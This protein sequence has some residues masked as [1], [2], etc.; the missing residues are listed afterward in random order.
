MN[1]PEYQRISF[2]ESP[3]DSK[4]DRT[5]RWED[6]LHTK[7]GSVGLAFP[8][9]DFRSSAL[10][11]SVGELQVVDFGS[12]PIAYQRSQR[13]VRRD[14]NNGHDN[15][16]RL[17]IPLEG[18]FKFAQGDSKE[19]FH[20]GKIVLCHWGSPFYMTHD[21]PIRALIMTVPEN[22]IH[23][24]S[25][26]D[27]PLALNETR[28]VVRMLDRAVRQLADD[29]EPW[30]TVDF[31]YAFSS[32]LRLLEGALTSN[33]AV[34]LRGTEKDI[35]RA[36]A[37]HLARIRIEQL[38][39]D[40]TVTPEAIAA[41]CGMSLKKLHIVLKETYDLTPG[42]MLRTIRLE[43]AR[44]QLLTPFPVDTTRIAAEAGFST[45]RRFREAFQ[46]QFGLTPAQ[47]REKLFGVGTKE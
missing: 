39:S 23:L 9:D 4:A 2:D 33:R 18:S 1:D 19:I 37:A 16:H 8:D 31:A 12:G 15:G 38:A 29:D 35:E 42:A 6:W 44:Q 22:S 36:K 21:E 17:I 14:H 32:A 24:P 45:P 11:R 13:D 7:Q 41:M 34:A 30:T 26:G 40:P 47:M 27:A 25:P 5:A 3:D 28:P 10:A 20:P 46:R 43:L